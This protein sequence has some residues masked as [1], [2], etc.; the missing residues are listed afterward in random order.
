MPRD[1]HEHT[2]NACLGE[3][4]RTLRRSW[5]EVTVYEETGHTSRGRP[6]VIVKDASGWPVV[7]EAERN[8]HREAE[9]DALKN[10]DRTLDGQPVEVA[11]ALVY[12]PDV[13][14]ERHLD[15]ITA[16]LDVTDGLE[17]CM[18]T[19]SGDGA[20]PRMPERGWVR[21]SVRDFALFVH[22]A[23]TP[24]PR[25][26]R[27]A[28]RFEEGVERAERIMTDVHGY[29]H[30]M[31][32]EM[33]RALYPMDNDDFSR[34]MAADD[35]AR[36][37]SLDNRQTRR[38]GMTVLVNALLFHQALAKAE[39]DVD[40]G[41]AN[42][43]RRKLRYVD[44]LPYLGIRELR[45]E[46]ERILRV[47]YWPI[48]DS[49]IKVSRRFGGEVGFNII[50]ELWRTARD[51]V[52]S[53]VT[54]SND[55]TGKIFQR[56]I[57]DREYL[58]THY[59]QPP[60]AALLAGLA[61]PLSRPIGGADWGDSETLAA[62]QIGDFACGSG[63]LLSAAYQRI[64]FFHEMQGGDAKLLHSRM[65]Q[66]GLVGMD[67]VH[68]AVHLTATMLAGA[69]PD[70]TFEGECLLK[71]PYGGADKENPRVGSLEL[72][73][74]VDQL[75]LIEAARAAINAQAM[76]M[77]GMEGK[78]EE[79]RQVVQRV[80]HH[81]FDIV[82]MNPPFTRPTN[83]ENKRDAAG[84]L[85]E[86][87]TNPA[88]AGLSLGSTPQERSATQSA[89]AEKVKA[90]TRRA[91][92]NDYAG[93]ASH[94][95]ELAHRKV[96][97]SGTVAFV[98]PLSAMSGKSWE[99]ARR[100]WRNEYQ[101]IVVVTI[102]GEG[103]FDKSF[104]Q[105]TGMGECLLIARRRLPQ[106]SGVGKQSARG[107][108]VS[109]NRKPATLLEGELLANEILR[110]REKGGLP[111]L[112]DEASLAR[113]AIGEADYG[114]IWTA[115]IPE[116]G[117]WPSVGVR[118]SDLAQTAMQLA[119]GRFVDPRSGQ[120]TRLAIVPME[121]V[122]RIGPV[123]RLVGSPTEMERGAFNVKLFRGQEH[124]DDEKKRKSEEGFIV[125]PAKR[126][127]ETLTHPILWAHH[128]LYERM[129]TLQPDAYGE[130]RPGSQ[131]PAGAESAVFFNADFHYNAQ[132]IFI[133][134]TERPC[135]GGRAWP[136]VAFGDNPDHA[137]AFALWCNSTLGLLMH[138]WMANKTHGGRGS[139]TVSSVPALPVL[140]V[141]ALTPGQVA[142]AK[143][144]FEELRER[145]LLPINQIHE[146][147]ARAEIDRRLIVDVLGLDA[148]LA[149]PDGPVDLL[150]R[151]LAAEP[152]IAG[153]KRER[154]FFT[155]E[156]RDGAPV[157]VERAT[158]RAQ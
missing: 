48:F 76:A 98:L 141:A 14:D 50:Q 9:A 4:L 8:N 77:R 26:E 123:D 11:I 91:P 78:N 24:A 133:G 103:D 1:A 119:Q 114:G 45:E 57:E 3:R 18:F 67:V 41:E 149:R 129:M 20:P 25:V 109:L 108:F 80:R 150:R 5:A 127:G 59:T 39:L 93:L 95:V 21:G 53:G 52:D 15:S 156:T 55:L 148:D 65:M 137:Y 32:V 84:R 151:K 142:A 122:A 54:R 42:G 35:W 144:V 136:A 38:M 40:D 66:H 60:A 34:D 120:T 44:D 31:G 134:T 97:T 147:D 64:A 92:S 116:R 36:A 155:E 130:R 33:A 118:D 126:V 100:H 113:L 71:M 140:D 12:P 157:I 81:Q 75:P 37:E 83:H 68:V 96:K 131:I 70:T 88:Y 28:A 13:R 110:L 16:A 58:A 43:G 51:L 124:K 47:N 87:E 86:K 102:A 132:S 152:Q 22:R 154:V 73:S 74:D 90:L 61:L 7:I 128:Y 105:D 46:W 111:A 135:V 117:V 79:V 72:L 145:P 94:F 146:D 85:R 17:Y 63:T 69:H 104:S 30:P 89:M 19:R 49:A 10:F 138:W 27:L 107:T 2:I 112:E 101:D 23:T 153:K 139:F 115:A 99:S 29:G 158:R 106:A 143:A 82:I 62:A 121:R 6:D 125:K 56:L